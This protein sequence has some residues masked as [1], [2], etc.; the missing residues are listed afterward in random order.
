MANI[1]IANPLLL[2]EAATDKSDEFVP[3]VKKGEL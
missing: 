1:Y 3:F 2:K